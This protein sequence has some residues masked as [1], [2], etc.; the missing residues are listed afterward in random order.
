MTVGIGLINAQ[1]IKSSAKIGG[2]TLK[3][4][5]SIMARSRNVDTNL[6]QLQTSL[7][8]S[9]T[10]SSNQT[11]AVVYSETF[12]TLPSGIEYV[13]Q[14]LPGLGWTVISGGVDRPFEA[15]ALQTSETTYL[16]GN[17]GSN[18][19]LYSPY[20]STIARNEWA[21]TPGVALVGGKTYIFKVYGIIPGYDGVKDEF[22]ITVGTATTVA[23]QS[24]VLMD[25]TGSNSISTTSWTPFTATYTPTTSGTYYFGFHHCGAAD[26]DFIMFDDVEI[27]EAA[28]VAPVADFTVTPTMLELGG[29]IKLSN[30]SQN[31]PTSF[32]WNITGFNPFTTNST[33]DLY[34]TL[35]EAGSYDIALT[36]I[37]NIGS[38]T[39]TENNAVTVSE[40]AYSTYPYDM[41][42]TSFLDPIHT[43]S[44]S[45]STWNTT[46]LTGPDAVTFGVY[47]TGG[48]LE[49][50]TPLYSKWF[51]FDAGNTYSLTN[52]KYIVRG[53]VLISS[54]LVKLEGT[55][56]A[57]VKNITSDNL[58]FA[59]ESYVGITDP[60]AEVQFTVPESGNYRIAYVPTAMTGV[61]TATTTYEPII[62]L[63]S[64]IVKDLGSSSIDA[65][66]NDNNVTV[67]AVNKGIFVSNVQNSQVVV[68]NPKGQIIASNSVSGSYTF[69]AEGGLYLVKVG[70]STYKVVVK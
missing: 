26:L 58:S 2:I 38:N 3:G 53:D 10:R 28:T 62:G 30:T 34:A 47:Y 33:E 41:S 48:S 1:D 54:N 29:V 57:T 44:W 52:H 50:V 20:H 64:I 51:Y 46:S 43:Y 35:D 23:A 5:S 32:T 8:L 12:E 13:S 70:T 37:N 60:V 69:Q 22:K 39:K 68:Y 18:Y 6:T 15:Y 17:N 36:A 27:S 24:T 11:Q 45:S 4:T 25:K 55:A 67:V 40:R 66:A 49:N 21:I 59:N 7:N 65:S 9:Q 63:A 42:G 31:D 14:V 56:Y 61:T 16:P 19:Y